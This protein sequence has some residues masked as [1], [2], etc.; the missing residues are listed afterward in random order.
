MAIL[1]YIFSCQV[2]S[3]SQRRASQ[4][5]H[6]R[7]TNYILLLKGKFDILCVTLSVLCVKI[8]A[9]ARIL[10]EK[11]AS[12]DNRLT[13]TEYCRTK[14]Y[15][16]TFRQFQH[17]CPLLLDMLEWKIRVITVKTIRIFTSLGSIRWRSFLHNFG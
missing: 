3:F 17:T 2:D 12:S 16:N 4:H 14:I 1:A 8:V 15:F 13:A 5:I 7:W 11:S 6:R 10:N 9:L